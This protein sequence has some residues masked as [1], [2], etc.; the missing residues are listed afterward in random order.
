MCR[1]V[2]VIHQNDS[3]LENMIIKRLSK[4]RAENNDRVAIINYG[5][6]KIESS[7]KYFDIIGYKGKT[8]ELRNLDYNS[9]FIHLPMFKIEKHIEL[10]HETDLIVLS[11]INSVVSLSDFQLASSIFNKSELF[12]KTTL[13][14]ET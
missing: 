6:D 4:R 10:L 8:S 13:I 14:F 3:V 5:D 7:L 2:T 11:S 12:N 1:I 9:V